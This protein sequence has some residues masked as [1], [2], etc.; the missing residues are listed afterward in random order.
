M[1]RLRQAGA[2]DVAEIALRVVSICVGVFFLGMGVNKLGWIAQPELLTDRLVRWVP[3]AAMYARWYL[4]TIAIPGGSVFARLVPLAELATA[5]CLIAGVRI[6]VVAAAA[7][8]M[9]VNFH[10]AT[11]AFS[12]WA[13]VRDGTGLPVMGALFALALAGDAL[14]WCVGLPQRVTR[15]VNVSEEPYS[16][17]P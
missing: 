6:R 3:D 10:L 1:P 9:V 17:A 8:F 12:S 4:E 13:F 11:S 5:T 2:H 7:F 16:P 14:P 15:T